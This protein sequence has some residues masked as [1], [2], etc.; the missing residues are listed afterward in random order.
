MTAADDRGAE[1][2][3]VTSGT[4]AG[5]GRGDCMALTM[6]AGT[7]P[8]SSG[9]RSLD[10]MTCAGAITVSQWQMFSN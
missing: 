7:T 8:I 2:R 6:G 4:T 3:L 1:G 9:G 5:L 10:S